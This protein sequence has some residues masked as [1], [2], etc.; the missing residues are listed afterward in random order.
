MAIKLG[1]ENFVET[2]MKA[3]NLVR[4]I[5]LSFF[6]FFSF[7]ECTHKPSFQE[8]NLSVELCYLLTKG[9]AQNTSQLNFSTQ[10][11]FIS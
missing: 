1:L 5:K 2:I 10:I 7:S 4:L 11:L 9:A 6:H 3:L 8:L